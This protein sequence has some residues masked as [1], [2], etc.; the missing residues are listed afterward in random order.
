MM[1]KF[2]FCFMLFT[3]SM[4]T[5]G[6]TTNTIESSQ[7]LELRRRMLFFARLHDLRQ[8]QS[9]FVGDYIKSNSICFSTA[10]TIAQSLAKDAF[11]KLESG[12]PGANFS[13][14]SRLLAFV[15]HYGDKQNLNFLAQT[16]QATNK[17]IRAESAC[18][19]IRLAG[20]ESLPFVKGTFTNDVYTGYDREVIFK[21]FNRILKEDKEKLAS[22]KMDQIHSFYFEVLQNE[23]DGGCVALID[24]TLC[25]ALDEYKYSLQRLACVTRFTENGNTYYKHHFGKIKDE[26]EKTPKEKRKDFKAKGD[27]LDPDKTNDK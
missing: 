10:A 13:E 5:F 26:I 14:Y 22:K 11:T 19:Y 9:D 18:A 7:E 4:W 21:T 16:S 15:S 2:C 23:R 20:V 8:V 27:L 25:E 24:N 12:Q 6:G 3:S 17:Y 1:K